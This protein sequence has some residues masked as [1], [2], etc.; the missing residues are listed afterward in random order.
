MRRRRQEDCAYYPSQPSQDDITTPHAQADNRLSNN[1]QVTAQYDVQSQDL[2]TDEPTMGVLPNQ[3]SVTRQDP[4]N[5]SGSN[6]L[7]ELFGYF[8]YSERNT[9]ALVGNL[10]LNVSRD[11]RNQDLTPEASQEVQQQ[12]A[13]MADRRVYDFLVQYYINEVH[14]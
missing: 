12:M 1:Q 8:E 6:S 2:D 11:C 9:I 10:G 7:A 4:M 13:K 5:G 14:C 3:D